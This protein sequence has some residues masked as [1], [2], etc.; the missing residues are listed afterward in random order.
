MLKL[1]IVVL[2]LF[3][4]SSVF[5]HS[6]E[7]V[8]HTVELPTVFFE[9][10]QFFSPLE[11]AAQKNVLIQNVPQFDPSLGVLQSV[12][13]SAS[14]DWSMALNMQAFEI[15]NPEFG[16]DANTFNNG[17]E[18]GISGLSTIP[19]FVY[20]YFNSGSGI[21]LQCS[22][23][24]GSA[25]CVASEFHLLPGSLD[26]TTLVFPVGPVGNGWLSSLYVSIRHAIGP[27]GTT[28][29]VG[30][31][32]LNID[33]LFIGGTL[34]VTYVY[35]EFGAI[36]GFDSDFDGIDNPSDS[37]RFIP[38]PD[39][40]DSD[41]DG[42]GNTCDADLNND[43]VVNFIDFGI[44]SERFLSSDA[45]ADFN[46]DGAVN[47]L[48]LSILTN[49]FLMEP[50]PSG[51]TNC[52]VTVADHGFDGG[53]E[54]WGGAFAIEYVA[55]GGNPDGFL[56]FVDPGQSGGAFVFAP[57][58][59]LGDWSDFD[60]S[61]QIQFDHKIFLAES[62]FLPVRIKISGPGGVAQWSGVVPNGPTDWER[63]VVPIRQ[64]LFDQ[65]SG[66]WEATLAEVEEV[67]IKISAASN[68]VDVTG[69]DNVAIYRF[70][71]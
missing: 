71:D 47:F 69:I 12:R 55:E 65:L 57:D 43:C 34:D 53:F 52:R 9:T 31:V 64:E 21:Y 56:R 25:G 11:F 54:G 37:C 44:W 6:I 42:I 15:T 10:T 20:N 62:E 14:W 36:S 66:T 18:A 28:L 39:Q 19:P 61:G 32:A 45:D 70:E 35:E 38:N 30:N 26:N 5:A 2:A 7:E 17:T 8:T 3:F 22:G 68:N 63:R 23:E 58:D 60:R 29:N 16:H 48:D 24:P 4:L 40:I 51:Y 13:I 59:Y 46:G 1:R 50:G 33:S 27:G 41:G 49:S 67:S